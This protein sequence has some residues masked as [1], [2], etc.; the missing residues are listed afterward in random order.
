[1][2]VVRRVVLLMWGELSSEWNE[3]SSEC[4]AIFLLGELSWSEL[5]LGRVV[6]DPMEYG[7]RPQ[8]I[9]LYSFIIIGPISYC[10]S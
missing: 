7:P 2:S 3:L 9:L 10:H 8:L 6:H 5:S 4:G 1:M